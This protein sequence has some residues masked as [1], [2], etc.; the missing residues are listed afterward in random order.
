V[1]VPARERVVPGGRS[2]AGSYQNNG[3]RYHPGLLMETE[4]CN[5]SKVPGIGRRSLTLNTGDGRKMKGKIAW[6]RCKAY[7]DGT[8]NEYPQLICSLRPD[9]P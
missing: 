3:S 1:V 7:H 4:P 5:G 6:E 2:G 9:V 8:T